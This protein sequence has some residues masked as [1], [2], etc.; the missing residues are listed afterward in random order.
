LTISRESPSTNSI[1]FALFTRSSIGGS[2]WTMFFPALVV[3]GLGMAISVAPLTTTVMNSVDQNHAGTASGVNNA[4]SRIAA[5][6]AVGA[7]RRRVG[8]ARTCIPEFLDFHG[9]SL[10]EIAHDAPEASEASKFLAWVDTVP[11]DGVQREFMVAA[12]GQLTTEEMRGAVAK[13]AESRSKTGRLLSHAETLRRARQRV[14]EQH[15]RSIS[16]RR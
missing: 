11:M 2:Y 6:L 9:M 7:R 13:R 15:V 1:G 16:P 3:L 5:L 4:V 12:H 8:N 10:G 14:H